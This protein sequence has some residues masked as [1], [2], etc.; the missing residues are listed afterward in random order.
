M[1]YKHFQIRTKR[2]AH[3]RDII[4]GDLHGMYDLLMDELGKIN[5]NRKTDRLFSVGDLID[6]GPDSL[7]CLK[8]IDEDWFYPV[9]GNHED[10]MCRNFYSDE[11]YS[12]RINGGD[13]ID[14]EDA[15]VVKSYADKIISS[16]PISRVVE[17][18]NGN[19]AGICHAQPHS[20]TFIQD[21]EI[22]R[23]IYNTMLWGRN[24]I[25]D[26]IGTKMIDVDKT[27]HGHT[28]LDEPLILGDQIYIDTGAVFGGTLTLLEFT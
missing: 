1:L 26:R 8:L 10:M 14:N 13:W 28:P 3:G 21:G 6:R 27:I 19:L 25:Q 23:K 16:V 18:K 2:N 17:T 22:N 15:E 4:I 5:F 20:T 11:A 7:K 9:I 24:L 12:W